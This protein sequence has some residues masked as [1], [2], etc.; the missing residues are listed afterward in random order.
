MTV[1]IFAKMLDYTEDAEGKVVEGSKKKKRK[2]SEYW[3]FIRRIGSKERKKGS[4][5]SGRR[6]ARDA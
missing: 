3:T 6:R 5:G 4:G 2:F 1:R